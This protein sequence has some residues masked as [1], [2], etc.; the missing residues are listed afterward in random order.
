MRKLIVVG[1]STN[2]RH[3]YS[4]VQYHK[5]FDVIGFAVS[6]QYKN[7]DTF[8]DLPVFALEDIEQYVDVQEVEF[9]VALLWNRL[10]AD[11]KYLYNTLKNKNYKLANLISPTAAIRGTLLG[12]NC[13]IHDY[14]VIQNNTTIGSN[15]AI[16]AQSI[17]GANTT[18]EDHC[19]FGARSIIGGGSRIGEQ[20]F[21]GMNCTV[22]DGTTVGKKCILGACTAIKR[23]VPD[24]TLCKTSIEYQMKQYAEDEIENKLLAGKIVR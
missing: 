24:F 6:R 20:S 13:W 11:R 8:F 2:A 7:Q 17:I 18:V 5:L 3:V 1:I 4:F 15:V 10:N 9:F 22:F 21:I 14:V 23:N 19:F 12:D 16:M